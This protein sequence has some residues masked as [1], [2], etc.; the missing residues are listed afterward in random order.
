VCARRDRRYRFF[1]AGQFCHASLPIAVRGR[2]L[3]GNRATARRNTE[4]AQKEQ[5]F[6]RGFE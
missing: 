5:L 2:R 4:A 3:P 6:P 1:Q